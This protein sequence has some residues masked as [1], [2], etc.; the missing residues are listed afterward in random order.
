MLALILNLPSMSGLHQTQN[1]I[2]SNIIF[3]IRKVQSLFFMS[4]APDFVVLLFCVSCQ[5]ILNTLKAFFYLYHKLVR[6]VSYL[7]YL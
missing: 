4:C 1:A 3:F 2:A 7:S 6:F 5:R